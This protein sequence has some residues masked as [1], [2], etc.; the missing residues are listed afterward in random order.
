MRSRAPQAQTSAAVAVGEAIRLRSLAPPPACCAP[1]NAARDCPRSTAAAERVVDD[2]EIRVQIVPGS[3]GR[4]SPRTHNGPRRAATRCDAP[5]LVRNGSAPAR[6]ADAPARVAGA[7]PAPPFGRAGAIEP[8]DGFAADLPL[9]KQCT[10]RELP[11]MAARTS[12][13]A[14]RL[15]HAKTSSTKIVTPRL[16]RTPVRRALASPTAVG[17]PFADPCV[18]SSTNTSNTQP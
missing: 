7:P 3:A 2:G 10:R 5:A 18:S 1:G 14:S 11:Q 4:E 13:V 15:D 17:H 8:R 9:R 6:V 16:R 12:L